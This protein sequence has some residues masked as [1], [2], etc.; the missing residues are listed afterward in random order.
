MI[1]KQLICL[2]TILGILS[3]FIRLDKTELKSTYTIQ[4][5]GNRL[6]NFLVLLYFIC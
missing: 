6:I 1:H 5:F 3:E 2:Q 4:Q